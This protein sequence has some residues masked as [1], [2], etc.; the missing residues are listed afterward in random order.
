MQSKRGI[1]AQNKGRESSVGRKRLGSAIM[2]VLAFVRSES[3]ARY[4]PED[5]CQSRTQDRHKDNH[6]N[7]TTEKELLHE[8]PTDG[9]CPE[10][11]RLGLEKENEDRILFILVRY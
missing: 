6:P 5:K 11:G 4:G 3:V 7:G 10:G 9:E 1:V 8:R 2:C